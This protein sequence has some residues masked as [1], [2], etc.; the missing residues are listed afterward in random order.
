MAVMD[1]EAC[2]AA[3]QLNFG[4]CLTEVNERWRK[5]SRIHHPDRHMSDPKAYRQALEK[6]KQLN[7]ARD[8]LKKWFEANPHSSPPKTPSSSTQNSSRSYS[9]GSNSTHGQQT[10][11]QSQST[12]NRT[13]QSSGQSYRSQQQTHSEHYHRDHTKHSHGSTSS[14][15]ST[16]STTGATTSWFKTTDLKLTPLQ[17]WV[18][19][20]DAYCNRPNS[21]SAT[22][23]AMAL[24]FAAVFGPLWIIT[25]TLGFIFPDL[26]GHY[27][28]W[29]MPFLLG[30]SGYITTY[31][32]RWYFAETQIIKLQEQARYFRTD[33]TVQNSIE[34]LKMTI[35]KQTRQ[36]TEWK[37]IPS[38]TAQEAILE[39]EEEVL[40][41]LKRPRRIVLRFEV[42]D[43]T[44]GRMVGLEVRTAS[45][46]N[47]FSCK[48]IAE[49][50]LVELKKDFQ[51]VAA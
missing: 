2:Y 15:R 47:S 27:P 42:K 46:I 39:F 22:A 19:K 49:S 28:D 33:R 34:Y 6:Q 20:T 4:A 24:G 35:G 8:I 45:P 30:G 29:L 37:F 5:L 48:E 12:N 16:S 17:E 18:K 51:E 7:N 21:D 26:P 36:N 9:A 43:S 44:V 10:G 31:L 23:L 3:L 13:Q 1:Y 14:S 50:V 40:P 38:G 41:D 32:F 25:A 11:Q